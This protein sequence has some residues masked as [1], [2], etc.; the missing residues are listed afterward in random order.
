MK[1]PKWIGWITGGIGVIIILLA[2][3]SLLTGKNIFGFTHVVNYFHAANSF[4]LITIALFVVV[5]RCECN[6]K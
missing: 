3:I 6:G 1:T 5:Y 4:F 2:A